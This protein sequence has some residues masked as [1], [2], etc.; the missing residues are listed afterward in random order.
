[1]KNE[2]NNLEIFS[3]RLKDPVQWLSKAVELISVADILKNK[4][5]FHWKK[6]S[7]EK[8]KIIFDN[9]MATM[10]GVYYMLMAFAIENFCK[11]IIVGRKMKEW[12][13]MTLSKIPKVLKNHD[14]FDLV[15]NEIGLRVDVAEQILLKKLSRYATWHARYPTPTVADSIGK[16]KL[17]DG[18]EYSLGFVASFDLDG[19]M[20]FIGCLRILIKTELGRDI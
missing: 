18:L 13:A 19:I 9:N 5:D 1:M 12:E 4:L 6:V 10:Q 3:K 2:L 16:E 7:D 20:D 8:G 14:L 15:K 11:A 17:S